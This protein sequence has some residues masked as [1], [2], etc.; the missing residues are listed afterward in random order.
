MLSWR[1]KNSPFILRR[2]PELPFAIRLGPGE[3]VGRHLR[4]EASYGRQIRQVLTVTRGGAV[5][6]SSSGAI[7]VRLL[8]RA[9]GVLWE[10]ATVTGLG[11]W[12]WL[13]SPWLLLVVG[14][15]PL[16]RWLQFTI[17]AVGERTAYRLRWRD[18]V[19]IGPLGLLA[20]LAYAIGIITPFRRDGRSAPVSSA[21]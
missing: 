1:L 15:P 5:R 17:R 14:V 13:R 18:I 3:G 16:L 19:S 12:V 6:K 8:N 7:D 9:A 4:K 21:S 10:L 11:L 2:T 20:D